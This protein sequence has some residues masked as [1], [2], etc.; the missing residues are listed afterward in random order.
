MPVPR[1]SRC[2][3]LCGSSATS[4]HWCPSGWHST[5]VYVLGHWTVEI[6]IKF[7]E[8]L[9][10]EHRTATKIGKPGKTAELKSLVLLPLFKL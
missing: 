2:E 8:V 9:M 4:Q 6:K 5:P 3:G 7:A 10:L 1:R